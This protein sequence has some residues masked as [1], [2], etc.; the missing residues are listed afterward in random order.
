MCWVKM[1]AKGKLLTIF[2]T[3]EF[4]ASINITEQANRNV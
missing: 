4:L 2:D 3:W 1:K